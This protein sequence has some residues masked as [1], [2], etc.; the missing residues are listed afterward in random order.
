MAETQLHYSAAHVWSSINFSGYIPADAKTPL[1]YKCI[2]G[3]VPATK[4]EPDQAEYKLFMPFLAF[5]S[6]SRVGRLSSIECNQYK[7][8]MYFEIFPSN[9]SNNDYYK[10]IRYYLV[11]IG[12]IHEGN[13]LLCVD[14]GG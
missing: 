2:S 6:C 4:T 3:Q 5:R 12:G 7:Q 1:Y 9:Q 13:I 8:D 11:Y 14:V 10:Y